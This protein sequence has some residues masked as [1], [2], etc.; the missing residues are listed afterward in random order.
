VWWL[1]AGA[2]QAAGGVAQKVIGLA[3]CPVLVVP[4]IPKE[5]RAS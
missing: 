4:P 3:E 2:G 5:T 1:L